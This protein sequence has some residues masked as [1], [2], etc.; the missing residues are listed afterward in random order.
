MRR[1]KPILIRYATI[2]GTFILL[3]M[4]KRGGGGGGGMS[5]KIRCT[6]QVISKDNF[7]MTSGVGGGS[8]CLFG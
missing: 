4:G 2:G 3:G 6:S 5:S 7:I 8:F 1:L